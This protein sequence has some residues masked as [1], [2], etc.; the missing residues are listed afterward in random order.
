MIFPYLMLVS[1]QKKEQCNIKD[2]KNALVY[3]VFLY[4]IRITSR[5]NDNIIQSFL[6]FFPILLGFC[7]V[8]F[9]VFF[10]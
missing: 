7:Y 6:S 3:I 4:D 10:Y 9:F 1:V 2:A 8:F 5:I